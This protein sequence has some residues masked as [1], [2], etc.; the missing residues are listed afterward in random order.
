MSDEM[1]RLSKLWIRKTEI[2]AIEF[3]KVLGLDCDDLFATK[4]HAKGTIFCL[5]SRRSGYEE[6]MQKLKSSFA[7][8]H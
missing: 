4:I 3:D 5:N 1:I 6:D 8:H 2:I 7:N